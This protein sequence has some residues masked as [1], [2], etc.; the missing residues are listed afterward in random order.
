M[1]MQLLAQGA[2]KV[3]VM[4]NGYIG[5]VALAA[6]S[7][8]SGVT[9]AFDPATLTLDGTS[10]GTASLTLTTATSAAPGPASVA[11]NVTAGGAT[12]SATVALTVE[13][14]ITLHIPA[15]VNDA[16]ACS[17]AA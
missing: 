10:T 1:S 13:S 5:T 2:V 7:L 9:A 12:K 6:A 8:P 14:T 3:T 17:D 4:P 16:G 15:G 11:V